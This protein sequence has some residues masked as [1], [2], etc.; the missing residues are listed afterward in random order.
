LNILVNSPGPLDGEEDIGIV[1][2]GA[3]AG[4]G[5]WNMRVNSPAGAEAGG[6]V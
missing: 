3:E 6:G 5:D 1:G 4:A 2:S